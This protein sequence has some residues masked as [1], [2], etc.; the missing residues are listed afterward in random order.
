MT[1]SILKN[2]FWIIFLL[3]GTTTAC[4]VTYSFSGASISPEVRTVSVDYFPN[5]VQRGSTVNPAMSQI[6][7]EAL[8]DKIISQTNLQMVESGGD[9]EFSG[10]ITG[11]QVSPVAITGKE[12]AGLNRFT[13][14]IHVKFT[15]NI[16]PE[17]DFDASFSRFEDYSSTQDFSAVEDDLIRKNVE[18][19]T[20][21]IFNKAFVNW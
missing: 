18:N 8:K 6:F 19:L 12:T 5:R 2:I 4:K 7:T 17:Q 9:V 14:T 15:N 21:D 3:T 16:D 10:E 20:E 1:T 11:Y 13:I